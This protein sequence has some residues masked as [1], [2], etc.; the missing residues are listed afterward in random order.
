MLP[1]LPYK[2]LIREDTRIDKQIRNSIRLSRAACRAVTPMHTRSGLY[3]T[4]VLKSVFGAIHF[5]DSLDPHTEL[6]EEIIPRKQNFSFAYLKLLETV[7]KFSGRTRPFHAPLDTSTQSHRAHNIHF[8][9]AT[10]NTVNGLYEWKI[11]LAS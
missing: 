2:S 11:A 5:G 4:R 6:C 1:S 10:I 9:G 8:V 3:S 7:D